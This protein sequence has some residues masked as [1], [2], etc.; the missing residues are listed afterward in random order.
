VCACVR[1]CVHAHAHVKHVHT[2]ACNMQQL[3]P[4][5]EVVQQART[6][7]QTTGARAP[8][9]QSLNGAPGPQLAVINWGPPHITHPHIPTS[10]RTSTHAHTSTPTRQRQ[11]Q[12]T[13]V[14]WSP[15]GPCPG[16]SADALRD[17]GVPL[18]RLR[19]AACEG[20][21]REQAV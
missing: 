17:A 4:S 12:P 10:T 16:P 6:Q 18:V 8:S 2:C 1:A 13:A 14:P 20:R 15:V 3:A 11:Q 21:V 9:L 5:P 19:P 7:P